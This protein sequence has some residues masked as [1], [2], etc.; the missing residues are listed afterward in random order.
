MGASSPEPPTYRYAHI[1][2]NC[3]C[4][5]RRKMRKLEKNWKMSISIRIIQKLQ[6]SFY[7]S[8]QISINSLSSGGSAPKLGLVMI[9]MK[10]F[11]WLIFMDS[12]KNHNFY[13]WNDFLRIILGPYAESSFLKSR[14]SLKTQSSFRLSLKDRCRD[15]G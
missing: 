7:F 13:D 2:L 9:F 10:W 8:I 11:L 5:L 4:N 14:T 15:T 6:I 1:F 12:Y 3:W